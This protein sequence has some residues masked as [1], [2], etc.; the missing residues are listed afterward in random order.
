[1]R[2]INFLLS[3]IVPFMFSLEDNQYVY[4]KES[5]SLKYLPSYQKTKDELIP[6]EIGDSRYD[7]VLNTLWR[8]LKELKYPDQLSKAFSK[9]LTTEQC[10]LL[11][12]A[13]V[14]LSFKIDVNGNVYDI[15]FYSKANIQEFI[16]T[17]DL[18]LIVETLKSQKVSLIVDESLREI[19]DDK[20]GTFWAY[21]TYH[22]SQWQRCIEEKN[23]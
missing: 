18:D 3:V 7:Y 19:Y 11:M 20:K 10:L 16:P 6:V 5:N 9:S 2:L 8:Q 15:Y 14:S 13:K 21:F 4:V 1:M 23:K 17:G 22:H 12:K